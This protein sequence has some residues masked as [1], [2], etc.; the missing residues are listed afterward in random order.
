MTEAT[1]TPIDQLKHILGI[2]EYDNLDSILAE[3]VGELERLYAAEAMT[4]H[5]R[6]DR[7][8]R[9]LNQKDEE[10]TRHFAEWLESRDDGY[11]REVAART[12]LA[13][14]LSIVDG[15]LCNFQSVTD[16]KGNTMDINAAIGYIERQVEEEFRRITGIDPHAE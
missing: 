10:R 12:V 11:R 9:R 8:M 15:V 5:E 14:V 4:P 7:F 2:E 1:R 3:A 13:R 16:G 6:E